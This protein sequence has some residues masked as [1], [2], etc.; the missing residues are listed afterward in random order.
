MAL[1]IRFV[2]SI[3]D[4]AVAEYADMARLGH[5]TPARMTEIMNLLHLA[6][7]IQE[8]LLFLPRV[9][10]GKDPITE[11]ELR[12]IVAEADWR[13]QRKEWAASRVSE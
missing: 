10:E 13:K 6:P 12:P 4:G 1:A 7:G 5:V 8:Q 9:M 2:K 11:R 3:R